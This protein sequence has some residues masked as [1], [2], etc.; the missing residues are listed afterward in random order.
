MVVVFVV[1]L[2]MILVVA[3]SVVAAFALPHLR[4]GAP[5][6]T[7]RGDQIARRAGRPLRPVRDA[8][9]P[10]L[11]VVVRPPARL[12]RFAVRPLARRLEPVT[13]ALA[14]AVTD[15]TEPVPSYRRP[16]APAGRP[17]AP[18]SP[19]AGQDRPLVLR[20]TLPGGA[21]GRPERVATP[22]ARR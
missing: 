7:D 12:V 15:G 6:L 17:P 11:V 16:A 3:L 20:M 2:L 8:V 21:P 5:V 9:W 14:E 18:T 10:R 22:V 13:Q 19:A 4:A 1:T